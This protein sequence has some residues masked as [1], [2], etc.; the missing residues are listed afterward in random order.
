[1]PPPHD[2]AADPRPRTAPHPLLRTLQRWFP[3]TAEVDR[4]TLRADLGAAPLAALL[5][6][7]QGIAFATLAGLPPAWGLYA[8]IVP[9]IVAALAGS[10][11]VLLTGPTNVLAVAL[12]ASLAPLAAAG[13]PEYLALALGVTLLVG[14]VQ[15]AAALLRLG[16]LAHFISPAVLLGFTTGA[17]VLIAWQALRS[18]L[19]LPP[20]WPLGDTDVLATFSPSPADLLVAGVT[21]AAALVLRQVPATSRAGMPLLLGLAVGM[22][23]AAALRLLGTG[24]ATPVVGPLPAA[25]PPFAVPPL[26]LSDVPQMAGIALALTLIA[27]GQTMAIAKTLAQRSGHALDSNR[28]CLG[29]GLANMSGAFFSSFVVCGSFNRSMPHQEAGARTPLSA[30]AAALLLLALVALAAPL[31]AHIPMPAVQ[32]VL[33]VVAASLIEPAR[34]RELLRLDRREAGVA[35]GTFAAMLLLPIEVAILAGVGASLL[36]YLYRSAH[37]ALRS[38]GFGE[39]PSPGR[40]RPFVVLPPG[41]KRCPQLEMLR[42]EGDVFFGAV[43]H[44]A[45]HLQAL[46]DEPVPAR[47]LLVMAKSMN[48]I[49][50]A[51]AALWEDELRQRQLMD[52]RLYFHR[53]RPDVMAAWG[54][55][56]FVQRL[57]ADNLFA[58]K[59]EAIATIVPQLDSAVCAGCRARIFEEC[60][61]Q[62]GAAAHAERKRAQGEASE[63]G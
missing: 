7:P 48:F 10:S 32:G 47:H 6:L 49:D 17:A 36:V 60:A 62:P 40:E 59:R 23:L 27:L 12:A 56:G 21:V 26:R 34:W 41:G 31:L 19:G 13:S 24:W 4:R 2:P 14:I 20:G 42:M 1:M 3:W 58:S 46:R 16:T 45:A 5:V 63:A 39:P 51:G 30:L 38:M 18:L 55:S 28:E 37:P 9:G 15:T 8:A 54:A 61:G 50:A 44:V 43:P 33:L 52:G 11:R 25:W 53:P 35:A 22:A 29:Q 57:G